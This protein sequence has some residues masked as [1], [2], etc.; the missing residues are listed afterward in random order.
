MARRRGRFGKPLT[1]RQ[2][3]AEEIESFLEDNRT[4]IEDLCEKI[5]DEMS[6]QFNI[7]KGSAYKQVKKLLKQVA[8][9]GF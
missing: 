1:A 5:R 4:D 6:E 9:Y 8:K 3:E 7:S 2:E